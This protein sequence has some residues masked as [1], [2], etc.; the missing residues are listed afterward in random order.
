MS[1][2]IFAVTLFAADLAAS[3]SFYAT[4]FGAQPVFEDE[5]SAVFDFGGTLI[6][7]L[8]EAAAPEL[9]EPAKVA[10]PGSGVRT[11]FTLRVDDVDALA[12]A[13]Q[14]R[15]IELL[16]GP[17]DRPWGPRTA[18]FCDPDGHVWELAQ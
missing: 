15:G 7:V 2:R 9:V 18:S 13:L 12:A 17:I 8:H 3:K 5:S 14:A 10:P 1:K 6:N 4:A 16:N 11:V